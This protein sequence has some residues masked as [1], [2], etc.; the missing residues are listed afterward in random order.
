MRPS[1]WKAS[2]SAAVQ[3]NSLLAPGEA[4][5][6]LDVTSKVEHRGAQQPAVGGACPRF[7]FG[8][9]ELDVVEVVGDHADHVLEGQVAAVGKGD[10]AEEA[11]A[12]SLDLE[13]ARGLSR[14]ALAQ[15]D[16]FGPQHLG[17]IGCAAHLLGPGK[18]LR[19]R[20]Q[21]AKALDLRADA[22]QRGCELDRESAG[23]FQ[24]VAIER[25]L[26]IA[27][28]RL[29]PQGQ[30]LLVNGHVLDLVDRPGHRARQ[31]TEHHQ[32]EQQRYAEQDD[33]KEELG[34]NRHGYAQG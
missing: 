1:C 20:G 14:L 29:H 13:Q 26:S 5:Q 31:E 32:V 7:N 2:S 21:A 9:V 16:E 11:R 10:L 8:D 34:A 19:R 28:Q 25:G 6:F 15:R 4:A 17:G 33:E 22:A 18:L 30:R 23:A 27:E 12:G 3:A 24:L